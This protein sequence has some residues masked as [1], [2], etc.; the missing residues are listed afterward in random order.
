M[1]S[2]QQTTQVS[3]ASGS[4][5][6]LLIGNLTNS[7]STVTSLFMASFTLKNPPYAS[8]SNSITFLTQ[9]LVSGTYYSIDTGSV[10]VSAVTSTIS[11]SSASM[12][13]PSIGVISTISVSFTTVNALAT[14][15][16][17]IVTVPS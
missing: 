6:K 8:L 5:T 17:I 3:V 16:N 4:S 9:N 15:S 14:G 7:T 12:S 13:D 10:T 1:T 2:N 11:T